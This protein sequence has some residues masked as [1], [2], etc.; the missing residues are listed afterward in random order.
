MVPDAEEG[1]S[2]QHYED[3]RNENK[4]KKLETEKAILGRADGPCGRERAGS[5][6]LPC[7]EARSKTM[8]LSSFFVSLLSRSVN[9][10]AW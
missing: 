9:L 7:Q 3:S 1:N 5:A 10:E 2:W 8:S 4:S 6:S